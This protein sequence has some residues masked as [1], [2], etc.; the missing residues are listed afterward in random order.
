MHKKGSTLAKSQS[1]AQMQTEPPQVV[2]GQRPIPFSIEREIVVLKLIEHENIVNL[3]DIWENRGEIYLVMEYASGGELFDYVTS[4][5]RLPEQEAVRLFRQIIAALSSCHRFNVCHRDLKPENLLIDDKQNIKLA[6]FGMAA[7]QPEGRWLSTSC[8]SPH[9]AAPE[10]INGQQY[11]GTEVDIWSCGI[12]LFAMITGYLPFDGG[13]LMKTLRLIK[14]GTYRLPEDVSPEARDLIK[15]ILMQNPEQRIT[16]EEIWEHPLLKKWEGH[17]K[18]QLPEGTL[19]A[20]PPPPL[21]EDDCGKPITNHEDIDNEILRN[22][23]TLWHGY[24]KADLIERLMAEQPNHERLFYR[25]LMR[26]R[27]EQREDYREDHPGNTLKYSKSDYHHP[28]KPKKPV[29]RVAKGLAGN[30][31]R[32][33]SQYSI[34]SD[35][36]TGRRGSYYKKPSTAATN[37]SYDPYRASRSPMLEE[38]GSRTVIIRRD[39]SPSSLRHAAITRLQNEI[40]D[41]PSFTSDELRQTAHQ[42]KGP[43]STTTSKS[44]IASARRDRGIQ[45]GV[46]RKRSVKFQHNRQKSS[47]NVTNISNVTRTSRN[48]S[49]DADSRPTSKDTNHVMSEMQSTP[50]MPKNP[51]H[52]KRS[53]LPA[54]DI[55]LNKTRTTSG[56]WREDARKVSTEL[57]KICEEAFNRSSVTS[58]DVSRSRPN[59]SQDTDSPAT[60]PSVHQHAAGAGMTVNRGPPET[61]EQ[62]TASTAFKELA[63]TRRRIVDNWGDS[64]PDALAQIL[65]N[66]DQRID[67]ERTKM[68]QADQRA[69]SDPTNVTT[70]QTPQAASLRGQRM[71]S[72]TNTMDDLTDHRQDRAASDPGERKQDPSD[73]TVRLISPDPMSPGIPLEP[74]QVRKKNKILMPLNSLRGGSSQSEQTYERGGYDPRIHVKGNLDTIKEDPKSPKKNSTFGSTTAG[75]KWSWL[76]KR[77]LEQ[78]D[79]SSAPSEKALPQPL[80]KSEQPGGKSTPE[81]SSN[82]I[83]FKKDLV[84]SEEV[85]GQVDGKKWFPKMF[86]RKEKAGF[87]LLSRDHAILQDGNDDTASNISKEH[88]GT[89]KDIVRKSYPPATSIDA[90]AAASATQP[91][92]INQNWFAKFFHIKPA[93][94][95]LMLQISKANARKQIVKKLKEWRKYGTRDVVVE[96]RV[97][98]DVIRGR[99]DAQ[100]CEFLHFL[101]FYSKLIRPQIFI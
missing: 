6:D 29:K 72:N 100:N 17:H 7:L 94:R 9:Y 78:D 67:L 64:D 16:M 23:Q 24:N 44:S 42:K 53:R 36:G 8:G 73:N 18:R 60:A 43:A 28:L 45:A 49:S 38:G 39:P 51:L 86:S 58:S 19:L 63:R 35:D 27:E 57:S 98:G 95:V 30:H 69:A 40:P 4:Q 5:R 101:P 87:P 91:I 46:T 47:G 56:I 26:F 92:Q 10:I 61:P 34:V 89:G 52:L 83:H 13:E 55:G 1:V 21:H 68:K 15:R 70:R 11:R 14:R 25:E 76:G 75:R 85:Q 82:V 88:Q 65:V 2:V 12:I 84:T 79:T 37:A 50:P 81:E 71:P 97:G 48:A 3:Y 20:G 41:L 80:T 93:S 31:Y 99:V 74:I 33:G 32:R 62:H 90:A 77:G 96:K 66:L 54:A 59:T 22:L